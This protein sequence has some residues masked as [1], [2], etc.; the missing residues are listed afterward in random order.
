M[1]SKMEEEGGETSP[2]A[3]LLSSKH[4]LVLNLNPPS[5]PLALPEGV[6]WVSSDG[7][8]FHHVTDA[9]RASADPGPVST[10]GKNW[11]L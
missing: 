6:G 10:N 11:G 7:A 2:M 9:H 3:L 4:F 5:S 8:Q 1:E